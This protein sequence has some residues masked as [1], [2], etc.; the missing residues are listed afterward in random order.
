LVFGKRWG[1]TREGEKKEQH[2]SNQEILAPREH[3][4]PRE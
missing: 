3:G 1:R 2:E 4:E